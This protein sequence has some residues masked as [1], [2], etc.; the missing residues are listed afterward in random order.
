MTDQNTI[1]YKIKKYRKE[2]GM[3][4]EELSSRSGI[5]LSTIKKYET[6]YRNPKPEQLLKISSALGVS[7]NAFIEFEISTVSD[8]I[9]LLMRMDEQTDMIWTVEKDNT[10]NYIPGTISISFKD[11]QIN[12]ALSTYMNYREQKNSDIGTANTTSDEL[13]VDYISNDLTIVLEKTKNQLLLSN[14]N[15]IKKSA[16]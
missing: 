1:A 10:G 12:N 6:G 2:Q 11:E 16:P 13:S 7:I 14:A 15:I 8:V 3:S 5:N 4:Q 9:S